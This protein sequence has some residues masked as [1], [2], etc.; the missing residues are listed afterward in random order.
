MNEEQSNPGDIN[1][2]VPYHEHLTSEQLASLAMG[3]VL[4]VQT[5]C[6]NLLE[7]IKTIE[8]WVLSY[9]T[10][11]YKPPGGEKHLPLGEVLTDIYNRIGHE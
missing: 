1:L 5:D 9:S 11:H 6:A 7:R 8:N 3:G 2:D 10:P 4:K